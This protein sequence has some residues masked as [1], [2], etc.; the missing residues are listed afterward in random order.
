MVSSQEREKI[1][2]PAPSRC[3][4][5]TGAAR[6]LNPRGPLSLSLSLSLS[7]VDFSPTAGVATPSPR[8]RHPFGTAVPTSLGR[9]RSFRPQSAPTPLGG[10]GGS[11]AAEAD[12]VAAASAASTA[13]SPPTPHSPAVAAAAAAAAAFTAISPT[14]R[15]ALAWVD[16]GASGDWAGAL[17]TAAVAA[18]GGRRQLSTG[19][20]EGEGAE[21]DGGPTPPPVSAFFGGAAQAHPAPHPAPF[22]PP[23]APYAAYGPARQAAWQPQPQQPPHHAWG[24]QFHRPAFHHHAPFPAAAAVAHQHTPPAG[25]Y[26][27]FQPYA[28]PRPVAAPSP[29]QPVAAPS[30][31]QPARQPAPETVVRLAGLCASLGL[32]GEEGEAVSTVPLNARQRRSL[33]RACERA[34][35]SLT[36]NGGAA[37]GGKE[38]EG[39]GV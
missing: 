14:R 38:E 26:Q 9:I 31:P 32:C 24:G 20:E 12:R 13:T 18:D 17:S 7:P 30:T 4:R 36:A 35:V 1:E 22:H 15:S 19:D 21:E 11:A 23:H 3:A 27:Q 25:F 39:G 6:F 2:G 34:L 8:R 28:P 5:A 37:G 16:R 33:R 29:P 10:S